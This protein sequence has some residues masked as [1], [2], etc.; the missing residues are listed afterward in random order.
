MFV[1]CRRMERF[2]GF[3]LQF[4]VGFCYVLCRI[5]YRDWEAD[6]PVSV[7]STLKYHS[8]RSGYLT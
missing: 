8:G 4:D 1:S 7:E 3:L 5:D 2:C 6:T